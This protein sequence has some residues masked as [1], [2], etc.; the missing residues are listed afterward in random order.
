[1][2][3][4]TPARSLIITNNM[5]ILCEETRAC[6]AISSVTHYGFMIYDDDDKIA[7]FVSQTHTHR[8]ALLTRNG[9]AVAVADDDDD[10]RFSLVWAEWEAVMWFDG[11]S[12]EI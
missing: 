1:M 3:A 11:R 12:R 9:P 6:T 5:C 4:G 10:H 7:A 8:F 2:H